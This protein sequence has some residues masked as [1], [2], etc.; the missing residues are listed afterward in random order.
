VLGR[1]GGEQLLGIGLGSQAWEVIAHALFPLM[2]AMRAARRVMDR[3]SI[4]PAY[5]P[6]RAVDVPPQAE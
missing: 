6:G 3:V 1:Q 4:T 2:A 5:P